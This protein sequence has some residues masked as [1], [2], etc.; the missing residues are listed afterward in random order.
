MADDDGRYND[1]RATLIGAAIAIGL[2][3]LGIW[4]AQELTAAG[5]LQDCVMQGR[6]NCA[7]IQQSR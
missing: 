1:R 5:R 3:I 4:L 2:L 6:T 7:A